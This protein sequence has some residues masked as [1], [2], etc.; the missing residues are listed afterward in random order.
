MSLT[1]CV[2]CGSRAGASPDYEA[3]AGDVGTA[4]A[5]AGHALVYGGGEVGL[6]GVLARA[7]LAAGGQVY[8]YIP[9]R[10]LEREVGKRNITELIVTDTMF[11]RKA[12]MIERSHAFV[13]LPGGLGTLDEILEVV[14]LRQLGYHDSP[15]LLMD[16]CDYWASM[17]QLFEKVV[18]Q[19][20]A[21]ASV[22]E[23]TTYCATLDEMLKRLE[24]VSPARTPTAPL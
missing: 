10:L 3:L 19:R 16:R 20:F 7:A 8:G 22:L 14:T 13:I 2:F 24:A 12:M 5:A 23:L 15:I 11:A 4:L 21:E 1:V 17:R 9:Q 18:E 6:M